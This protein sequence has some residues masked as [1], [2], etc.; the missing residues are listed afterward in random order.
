MFKKNE[1][2]R[3]KWGI[4][5]NMIFEPVHI[6]K[7]EGFSDLAAKDVVEKYKI[8]SPKDKDKLQK[9]KEE[10]YTSGFYKGKID[11][12]PYKGQLVKDIK[13]KVKE[14][15]IKTNEADFYFEPEGLVKNRMD[16]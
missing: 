16:E 15:L 1:I 9:A 2:L 3:K 12:G 4:T 5:E 11:I 10:V 14:D 13:D 6:I 7:L 8:K